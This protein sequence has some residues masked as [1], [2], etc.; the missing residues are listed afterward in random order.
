MITPSEANLVYRVLDAN[1]NRAVEGLRV[2]EEFARFVISDP[3]ITSELKQLRHQLGVVCHPC[4][5]QWASQRDSRADVGA[6]ITAAGEYSRANLGD[7]VAANLG[8]TGQALRALE[9]YSKTGEAEF[10]SAI[11]K[12]RYQFYETEKNVKRVAWVKSCL[13]DRPVYVLTSATESLELFRHRVEELCRAGA[14]LIQLREKNLQDG[15]LLERAK[16]GVA[17]CQ[18]ANALFIVNDRPDIALMAGADGVHVGQE[19]FPVT[20]LR[21]MLPSRMLVGVSTQMSLVLSLM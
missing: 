17:A 20:D 4:I 1:Y 6:E 16:I 13:E 7:V 2:V 11:E 5:D 12:I 9:E 14:D 21:K 15:E 3:R 8:R 18:D 10:A 19:E